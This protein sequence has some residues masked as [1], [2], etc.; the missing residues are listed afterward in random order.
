MVRA[1]L[2][3]IGA[4]E[5]FG[6]NR[7]LAEVDR[8]FGSGL[9]SQPTLRQIS[10]ILRRLGRT[11]SIYLLRNGIPHHESRYVQSLEAKP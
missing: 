3:G 4:Q 5:P 11:G 7:I 8:R 10:D 6:P 2:E 9:R 1:V